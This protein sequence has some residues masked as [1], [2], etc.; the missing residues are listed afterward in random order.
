MKQK[1]LALL[2][3]ALLMPTSMW[4]A[5]AVGDIF[6]DGLLE[7]KV[8]SISPNEVSISGC[9]K[10]TDIEGVFTIPSSVKD[11][12][13]NSYSVK[14][15]GDFAL[16]SIANMTGVVIPES[17]TEIGKYAFYDCKGLT[18]ITI[19]SHVTEIGE[20]AFYKCTNLKSIE[21]PEGVI[22][23]GKYCQKPRLLLES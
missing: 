17:I 10:V 23:I 3:I 15:I 8:T 9:T 18:T 7:F 20:A 2:L 21:L 16:S 22:S 5:L 1:L 13:G 19:P 14:T 11:T 4:A 12:D 6:N